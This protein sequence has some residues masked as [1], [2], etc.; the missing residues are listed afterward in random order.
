MEGKS[1]CKTTQIWKDP[2]HE[3]DGVFF[4]NQYA[5]RGDLFEGL[6]IWNDEKYRRL[7]G[8]YPVI[9]MS[10]ANIKAVSYDDMEYKISETLAKLYEENSYLLDQGILSDN[11]V[12]YYKK[13][14]PGMAGRISSGAIN[15]MA[16][17]M[18]RCYDRKIIIIHSG[19]LMTW[20]LAARSRG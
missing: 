6:S 19:R 17:F 14:K 16:G 13:I 4:S 8:T 5:D 12:E 1:Y 18:Q 15:S 10:F 3:H 20:D 9:F 2:E 7:Q 11:E